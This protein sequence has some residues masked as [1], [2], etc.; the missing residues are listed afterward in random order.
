MEHAVMANAHF[1][2]SHAN[3]D[4]TLQLQHVKQI[5]V[6]ASHVQTFAKALI[7]NMMENAL[8]V[9]ASMI[10]CHAHLAAQQV[11]VKMIR[12]KE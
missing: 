3:L 5:L 1:S 7:K 2:N 9:H 10:N 8:M 6:Q 4:A 11:I 12:A